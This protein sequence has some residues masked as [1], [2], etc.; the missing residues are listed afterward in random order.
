[1]SDH[2]LFRAGLVHLLKSRGVHV[3]DSKRAD[4]TI[5]DLDH[6]S[7]DA[8]ALVRRMRQQAPETYLV[9]FGTPLRL[10]AAA[11]GI[12]DAE[13]ESTRA[14]LDA[15]VAAIAHRPRAPSAELTRAHRLWAALTAR[16]REVLRWLAAGRDNAAIA[17]ELGIGERAVK[18]HISAMLERFGVL[19]RSELA[20]LA[21]G[22]GIRPPGA[23]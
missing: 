20:L 11:D 6:A 10:A 17:R 14:E 2:I 9:V 1:M 18:A 8:P 16:Q 4:T 5:L 15:I 22:A 12:A 23:R 3:S 21:H 13:V 7:G 19:N